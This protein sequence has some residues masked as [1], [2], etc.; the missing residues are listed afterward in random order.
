GHLPSNY[1]TKRR[2]ERLGWHAGADLCRV[3][4]GDAIG[5][6]RFQ[7]HAHQLPEAAGRRWREADL[8][9]HCGRRGTHRLIWSND[10]LYFVTVDHYRSFVP[11]PP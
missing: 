7:D 6:D 1:V 5:G 9:E 4:P 3:A 8:D 10:G 2:A 11:V